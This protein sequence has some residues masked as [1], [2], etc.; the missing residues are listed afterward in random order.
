MPAT[1]YTLGN[2]TPGTACY[3]RYGLQ[4]AP[5]V[6]PATIL[7]PTGVPACSLEAGAM[8]LPSR[9]YNDNLQPLESIGSY[10]QLGQFAGRRE[11]GIRTQLI[12]TDG[13]FIALGKRGAYSAGAVLGLPLFTL[14]LGALAGTPETKAWAAVDCLINSVNLRWQSQSQMVTA[15]VDLWP[16]AILPATQ[17]AVAWSYPV[18]VLLWQNSSFLAS[19]YDLH[20]LVNSVGLSWANNLLRASMRKDYGGALAISRTAYAI[21][22]ALEVV[23]M[24]WECFDELPPELMQPSEWGT[25]HLQAVNSIGLLDVEVDYSKVRNFQQSPAPAGQFRMYTAD[26]AAIGLNITWTPI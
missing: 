9:M 4:S 6:T 20:P 15:D 10:Q 11:Y 2:Y 21:R 5:Y 1:L 17:Q 16:A 26:V 22:P 24:Q 7:D 19:T 23:Q 14:E 3:A 25:C 12:P 8:P 18:D 13:N